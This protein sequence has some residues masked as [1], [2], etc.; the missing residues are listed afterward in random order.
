MNLG[1]TSVTV[2][3]NGRHVPLAVGPDPAGLDFT[4]HGHRNIP[5]GKRPCA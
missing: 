1:K 2:T 3:A 5:V 4:P